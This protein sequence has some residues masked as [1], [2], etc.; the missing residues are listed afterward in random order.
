DAISTLAGVS[1]V[2][3]VEDGKIR[4][5]AVTVGVRSGGLV[6]ILNGLKGNEQL[7]AS[8]L[9]M[10]ATGVPVTVTGSA[11]PAAIAGQGGAR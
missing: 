10:L 3:I 2:Y 9:S 7:A 4:Q 11:S 1:N 5:Q 6:E 8:N